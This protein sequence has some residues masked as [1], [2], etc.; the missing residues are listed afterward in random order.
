MDAVNWEEQ[1]ERWTLSDIKKTF[2]SYLKAFQSYEKALCGL[3]PTE[4]ESYNIYY[5]QTRLLIKIFVEYMACDGYINLLQYVNLKDVPEINLVDLSLDSI[6]ERFE[7]VVEKFPKHCTWDFYFNLLTCYLTFVEIKENIKGEVLI[8]LTSK[9]INVA[10]QLLKSH[11]K[12]LED[13]CTI[14]ITEDPISI[15]IDN[16]QNNSEYN[17]QTGIG[18]KSRCNNTVTGELVEM[19]D[20]ITY[21]SFIDSLLLCYKYIEI[22][23]EC[24][25]ESR[26]SNDSLLNI[27]QINHLYDIINAFYFQVQ[28]IE[29]T[30]DFQDAQSSEIQLIKRSIEALTFVETGDILKLE[31]FI[32]NTDQS[33]IELVLS[34]VDVL[35]FAIDNFPKEVHWSLSTILNKVL[36]Q[37]QILL[38]NRRAEII[39]DPC[40]KFSNELS[41]VVFKLCDIMISRSDN[42][43][44]RFVIKKEELNDKF[45]DDNNTMDI[46]MKNAQILLDNASDLAHKSCGLREYIIDKL[47]RNHIYGQAIQ[48]IKLLSQQKPSSDVS[49]DINNHPF[50]STLI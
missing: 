3:Y 9:F 19:S 46:L 5:N 47:K 13:L 7:M 50:Y 17:L 36:T 4:E 18:V 1:A 38:S 12:Q 20:D 44:R 39:S 28:D 11:M 41:P 30:I 34:N 10:Y 2:T 27:I 31:N 35:Q 48:R 40:K 33:H 16:V 49:L 43:L 6:M 22:L 32:L 37:A 21:H 14:Q 26:I 8:N 29:K 45:T 15:E 25:L 23:M 42:E 24:L